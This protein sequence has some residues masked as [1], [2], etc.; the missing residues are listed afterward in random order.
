MNV[1]DEENDDNDWTSAYDLIKTILWDERL[2]R[3]S[4]TEKHR[5]RIFVRS[6]FRWWHRPKNVEIWLVTIAIGIV[7]C[8]KDVDKFKLEHPGL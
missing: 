5:T 4:I 3:K 8:C 7:W 2:L 1:T 6:S